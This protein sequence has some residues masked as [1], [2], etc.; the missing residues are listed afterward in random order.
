MTITLNPSRA[1]QVR[2]VTD[3]DLVQ[4][5]FRAAG[6]ALVP[7]REWVQWHLDHGTPLLE[8]LAIGGVKVPKSGAAA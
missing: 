6:A 4:E 5:A 7:R 8:I 1:D 2:T 3:V